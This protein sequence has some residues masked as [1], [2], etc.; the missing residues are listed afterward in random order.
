M[1]QV[2]CFTKAQ[3][4]SYLQLIYIV[5]GRNHALSSTGV[6]F[7]IQNAV[8]LGFSDAMWARVAK[9][10]SYSIGISVTQASNLLH[11]PVLYPPTF[12]MHLTSQQVKFSKIAVDSNTSICTTML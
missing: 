9:A 1:C 4:C 12:K 6:C 10:L 5:P 7:M 11:Q 2:S 3:K 8:I